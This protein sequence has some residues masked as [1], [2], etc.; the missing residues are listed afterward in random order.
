MKTPQERQAD[1]RR[2]KLEEVDKQ[3]RTGSLV[4]R[5]MTA[6]ERALHPARPPAPKRGGAG[7]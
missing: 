3:I 7:R 4:V 5:Q 6:E 2:Q 1:R